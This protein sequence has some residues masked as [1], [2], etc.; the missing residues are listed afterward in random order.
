MINLSKLKKNK[1]SAGK[2]ELITCLEIGKLLTSTL[3][4][5]DVFE[6]IM[7]RGSKL[8]KAQHW[9][10]LLKDE[11]TGE[12][13]FEIVVGADKSLFDP[14]KLSSNE[15]IAPYV[16]HTGVPMFVPD[17][18]QE[19]RFN[20]KV[21][22]KTGFITR[23]I[24][25]IPLSTHGKISGV[26]EIVNIEDAD[27][28]KAK[29]YPLLSILADYAAI[30]IEN[31]KY[32]SR[33]EKL[34]ITDEYT[35]LNNARYLHHFLDNFF[36]SPSQRQTNIAAVFIDIDNFK[37]IVDKYGHVHGSDVLRQI[38][39]TIKAFL[40]KDD[41]LIKYGGDEYVILFPGRN[42]EC[43]FKDCDQLASVLSK[44]PFIIENESIY[45]TASFGIASYPE[46]ASGKKEL[47][48]AADDALFKI[49]NSTKNNI[50]IA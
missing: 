14:I 9:S 11:T 15:G 23:S 43:A 50:G 28:F 37:T 47:L 42:A 13:T 32:V 7:I 26:I 21:D 34:S 5:K 8:I 16:A 3:N 44:T 24:I 29:D 33:I 41:I 18:T 17:V 22:L 48:I 6:L 45:L 10:L 30:A 1:F 2:D 39:Q 25:C 31:S 4:H 19:P 40:S 36:S 20:K 12:L 35:G 49:K 38:G 46:S 27:F